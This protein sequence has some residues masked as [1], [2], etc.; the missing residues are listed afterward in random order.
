M[1]QPETLNQAFEL[2]FT[3]TRSTGPVVGR[4]LTELKKRKIVG[5][6]ASDGRVIVPPMEY[7]PDTAEELSDF[8]D[9]GQEGDIVSFA[10]VKHPREAHPMDR[11]FAW[12]MIK[13]DGADVPMVHCVAA[14][15]EDT[16]ATGSR[17]RAV[18]A[19]ETKGF[20]TDIRCFELI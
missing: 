1:S 12:A 5:I 20:I 10:W 8:V 3:Y 7:D 18:W 14:D 13:L 6:K 9:V 11:P 2:G 4:F 17:V 15:S 16:V 19:D